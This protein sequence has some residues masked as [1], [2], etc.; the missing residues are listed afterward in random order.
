MTT[1]Q[2]TDALA[3]D[4]AL[5]ARHR[6]MWASGNYPELASDLIWS[7]GP[8]LVDSARVGPGHR[9]LDIAAGSGNAAIPAA[10]T[11]AQ[12]V[13]SDLTPELF[14]AGRRRAAEAGVEIEWHEADAEHLPYEDGSFDTALSCVG[15]MFAPFHERSAAELVRVI[16]P[17]GTI[18]LLSWTP[19]GFI[20]QMFRAMKP[21]AAP[22]PEGAQ[23]PPLWGDETHVRSLLGSEVSSLTASTRTI[24]IDHFEEPWQFREYFKSHYGPTIATYA[25]I[26][27]DAEQV[28]ALDAALDSLAAENLR[29]GVMEWE[30]LVVTATRA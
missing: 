11:G 22:A 6:G 19:S 2:T 17:G 16:R 20:G 25:R 28:A 8:V 12:V 29:D 18:G 21:F 1:T 4:A 30:Y 7:L 23:P 24:A 9:V 5:K 14:E 27:Q 10:R 26:S 15:I 3:A 13:A